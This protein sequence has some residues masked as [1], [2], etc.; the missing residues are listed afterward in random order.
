MRS[1]NKRHMNRAGKGG[2]SFFIG[3]STKLV[4]SRFLRHAMTLNERYISQ[5][6]LKYPV[7]RGLLV[8]ADSSPTAIADT[9]CTL[10]GG[11]P[12]VSSVVYTS[13]HVCVC[14][15]DSI[16]QKVYSAGESCT[17]EDPLTGTL[18]IPLLFRYGC[19]FPFLIPSTVA[20]SVLT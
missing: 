5:Q 10:Y 6:A 20:S 16:H 1:T 2:N 11:H 15:Y 7:L 8:D 9:M 4:M 18:C 13:C 3:Q 17:V 19:V 14:A 12:V